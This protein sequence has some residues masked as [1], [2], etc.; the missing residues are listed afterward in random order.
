MKTR[1]DIEDVKTTVLVTWIVDEATADPRSHGAR[2]RS[3]DARPH[4]GKIIGFA[5]WAHP[6]DP[7][8]DYQE[9][10]WIWPEGTEHDVLNDWARVMEEAEHAA[11]G[12]EPCYSE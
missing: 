2:N 9:P 12:S 4:D 7:Q 10:A 11:I 3:L 8:D 5:K 1:A 6:T